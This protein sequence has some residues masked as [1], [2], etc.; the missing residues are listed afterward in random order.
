MTE[1]ACP[2]VLGLFF[3]WSLHKAGLTHYER[4]VGVYEL[5]DMTVIQFMLSALAVAALLL[6]ASS[7]L[8]VAHGLPVPPSFLLADLV[9][10]LLFGFGMATS[11]YCTGTVVAQAGEGRLDAILGGV[12]GLITGATLFGLLEPRVMPLLT[13]VAVLGRATLPALLGV[14]PWLLFLVLGE[15]GVLICLLSRGS[16]GAR[17]ADRAAPPGRA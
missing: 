6:Q 1:I 8:G 13:R 14:S 12:P 11:G 17:A 2:V 16:R 10:G 15:I 5:R 9:G 4:I 7:D 3:G